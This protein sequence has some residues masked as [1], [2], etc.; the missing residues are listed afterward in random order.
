MVETIRLE[1]L[2][3]RVQRL[4]TL[5]TIYTR[6]SVLM[7][8]PNSSVAEIGRV[9][10]HD[11]AIA[12]KLLNVVNSSFYGFRQQITTVTRAMTMVGF[13]GLK[14]LMLALAVLPALGSLKH[15]EF[16]DA[17]FWSHAV[18]CAACARAAA[19]ILRLPDPE[20]SFTAGLLH[21]IGKLAEY[22]FMN[23]GFIKLLETS[24]VDNTPM[25][26]LE[27]SALGYTH[28]DV[29]RLLARKWQFPETLTEAI[30]W[31]HQPA[32]AQRGAQQAAVIHVADI[33][34][35]ALMLGD[36]YDARVPPL[37]ASAWELSGLKQ[38][39]IS[40]LMRRTE[41]EYEKG[42]SFVSIILNR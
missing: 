29:G 6:V 8:D 42:K 9:V 26:E 39:Q 31:H 28:A 2:A 41:T 3:D 25:H 10:A 27:M 5:P 17:V 14:E 36:P 12:A 23:E 7:A 11:Q 4:P 21:D 1:M 34:S 38:D 33:I 24:H 35:R 18:G 37:D 19:V 13:R 15:K 22:Q 32:R 30:A 16:N 40:L 20:E